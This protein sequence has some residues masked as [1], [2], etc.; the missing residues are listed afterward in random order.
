MAQFFLSRVSRTYPS[1]A[2]PTVATTAQEARC[3][4]SSA[5]PRFTSAAPEKPRILRFEVWDYLKAAMLR[6][7]RTS[8]VIGVASLGSATY[9]A[10]NYSPPALPD[11]VLKAFE[12]G[13]Q[14]RWDKKY[15]EDATADMIRLDVEKELKDVFYGGNSELSTSS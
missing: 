10:W 1:F 9:L 15:E 7:R 13:G 12:S 11:K 5:S 6:W 2:R 3:R 14:P 8:A 4:L